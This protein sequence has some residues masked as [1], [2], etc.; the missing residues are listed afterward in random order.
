M[1]AKSSHSLW[2][3]AWIRLRKNKLAFISLWVLLV[4]LLT[5]LILPATGLLHDPTTQKLSNSFAPPSGEHLLGT[6]KFGRDVLSRVIYGGRVSLIVGLIATS[7]SML[8]GILYGAISGYVGGK[9]DTIMMR[10]LDVLYAL[11]YLILVILFFVFVAAWLSELEDYFSL[12]LQWSKTT[13]NI[14]VNI[15]PLCIVIG[16]LGWYTMARVVRAQTI[17]LKNLE[18]VEA[19]RSLGLSNSQI[20]F[21]H[22]LPNLLGTIIVYSTLT[23]P[24]FILTEATLSFL[25]IGVRD[26]F[27]SW[28]SM[29]SEGANLM[30]TEP[31]LLIVP[32]LAFSITLFALNFLGDGLRDALDPKASKD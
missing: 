16:S 27:S 31:L 19:A 9:L 25:G 29:L 5:C 32:A 3:D 18:F 30:E 15:V 11:P 26:P 28:G 2:S 24:G 20:L 13:V 7:I 8:I 10:V 21:R 4:I 17:T 1:S 23:V 14:V 6:D 12:T 22:I